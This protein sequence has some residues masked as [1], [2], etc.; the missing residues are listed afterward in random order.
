MLK[1]WLGDGLGGLLFTTIKAGVLIAAI[2]VLAANYVARDV[3]SEN[4]YAARIAASE[5]QRLADLARDP[6]Y[7]PLTTGSIGAAR[8]TRIDPC[9]TR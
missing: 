7:D 5:R 8:D 4:G 3:H 2:S 1:N 9:N 6:R